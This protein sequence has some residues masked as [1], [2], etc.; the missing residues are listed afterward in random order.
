MV[1]TPENSPVITRL[2]LTGASIM[3]AAQRLRPRREDPRVVTTRVRAILH[4]VAEQGDAA[5]LAHT[6]E[7]DHV[8]LRSDELRVDAEEIRQAYRR[9][10]PAEVRA[11]RRTKRALEAVERQG[12]RRLQWHY[13]TPEGAQIRLRAQGLRSVGCY[14]PGGRA[15][16]PSS[17][18]MTVVPARLAG[19]HRIVV[20]TPPRPDKTLPPLLLVAADVCRADEIYRVGGAQAIGAMAFGTATIPAVDKIVGPGNIFVTV[21]KGLVRDRVDIDAPAGPTEL[22]ILA[23]GTPDP[24]TVANELIAQAEHSTESWCGLLTTDA[25]LADAVIDAV[26]RALAQID[27][28]DIVEAALRAHGFVA[29]CGTMEQAAAITSELAPEHVLILARRARQLAPR[30][31]SAGLIVMGDGGAIPAADYALGTNHVLPTDGSSRVLTGLSVLDFVQRR[32]E[33]QCSP[34]TLRRLAPTIRTLALAE[35][36]TNHWRAVETRLA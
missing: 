16:Y 23:D 27:R 3:E 25:Q 6:R 12:L 30:I 36:L 7:F 28:R 34:R 9:V 14:V 20:C 22:V 5:I 11:L 8:V 26:Q 2:T 10:K 19:V 21:A 32:Y 4:A 17:L 15:A 29:V 33:V 18:L 24:R 1:K 31:A 35:G 13:T